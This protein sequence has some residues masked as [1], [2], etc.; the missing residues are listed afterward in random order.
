MKVARKGSCT[1]CV[2]V[3][4]H[5]LGFKNKP[6]IATALNHCVCRNK[7]VHI[8][9]RQ[10]YVSGRIYVELDG[11]A[12]YN[13]MFVI[14]VP[15]V[16][17]F[18]AGLHDMALTIISVDALMNHSCGKVYIMFIASWPFF[19]F[20][21]AKTRIIC[22]CGA[23]LVKLLLLVVD[24]ECSMES[25]VRI[26]TIEMSVCVGEKYL[27]PLWKLNELCVARSCES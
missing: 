8:W 19:F 4:E 16:S 2:L 27:D 15:A 17:T 21:L 9:L 24:I 13:S 20:L 23:L 12:Y 7:C 18:M 5:L 25:Y 14:V 10:K 1:L 6:G 26:C 11:K 22:H 3:S